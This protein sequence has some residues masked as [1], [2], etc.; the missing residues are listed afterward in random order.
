MKSY[1]FY[2]NYNLINYKVVINGFYH[3]R[4]FFV[5]QTL[6]PHNNKCRKLS[7]TKVDFIW[8]YNKYWL[9]LRA[10]TWLEMLGMF[11]QIS[12]KLHEFY[13]INNSH[14]DRYIQFIKNFNQFC[15]KSCSNH[16]CAKLT[17]F[18]SPYNL[19]WNLLL[20]PGTSVLFW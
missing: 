5:I 18:I 17:Q 2:V 15:Q 16:V 11:L 19:T 8:L 7:N 3:K 4:C 14:S 12:N 10:L 9:S 6:L 20:F 13:F 1:N